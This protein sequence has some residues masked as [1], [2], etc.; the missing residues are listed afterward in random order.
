[1]LKAVI[2][3]NIWISALLG[4]GNP[5]KIK[6]HL[7]QEHYQAICS[8]ELVDELLDVLSRPKFAQKIT[9]IDA[10]DLVRLLKRAATFV[11]PEEL[12]QT[13]RD[14]KDDVF[15]ACSI[16]AG[17]DYLVTGDQDLLSLGEFQGTKI[18]TA[19]EFLQLLESS[20]D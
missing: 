12:A 5:K 9:D 2:D 18:V 15:L 4:I 17:A 6:D 11:Q 16:A 20:P 3:T 14:P 7:S 19:R 1:M 8:T 13:S 10:A